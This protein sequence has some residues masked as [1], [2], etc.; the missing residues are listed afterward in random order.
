MEI[1]LAD[2]NIDTTNL[3]LHTVKIYQPDWNITNIISGKECLNSIVNGN[4][5]DIVIIGIQL[6][7]IP[8]LE[9]LEQIRSISDVPIIFLADNTEINKLVTV[10]DMGADDYVSVPFNTAVFIAR[11][12]AKV[13][14]NIWDINNSQLELK[15]KLNALDK[16]S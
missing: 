9:L 12:T 15:N 5:P 13:R 2:E 11:I 7:D 4:N 6:S 16:Y 1:L 8:E 10:F 3:I 14:R